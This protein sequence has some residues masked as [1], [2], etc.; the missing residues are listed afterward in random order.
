MTNNFTGTLPQVLAN[1]GNLYEGNLKA[2]F[3]ILVK[4]ARNIRFGYHNL[5]HMCHVT[6]LCYQ[7]CVY[8]HNVLTSRQMRNLLVAAIFHDFDHSGQFGNDDLNIERSIRGLIKYILPEDL[9]YL[10]DIIAIIRPTEFPPVTPAVTLS[11]Q[12]ICDADLSQAF[13]PVWVQEVILGLSEEWNKTP[14]EVFRMQK[15]FINSIK[16]KTEWAEFTFTKEIRDAKI[17]ESE[18]LLEMLED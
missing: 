8:Y 12:I 5:R 18:A 15:P 3:N 16:Y 4:Y 2:Y 6:W 14:I 7:A 1:T 17:E 10:D 11:Q 9:P 13:S